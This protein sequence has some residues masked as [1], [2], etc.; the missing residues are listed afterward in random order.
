MMIKGPIALQVQ[1]YLCKKL[2][3]YWDQNFQLTRDQISNVFQSVE[4]K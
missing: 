3:K 4:I 1:G 2:K